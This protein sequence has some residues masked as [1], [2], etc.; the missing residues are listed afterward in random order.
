MGLYDMNGNAWEWTLD[1]CN[2]TNYSDGMV[3]ISTAANWNK[4]GSSGDG[5]TANNPFIDPVY[6]TG[7]ARA[8]RGGSWKHGA[9]AFPLGYRSGESVPA[10]LGNNISFRV[11]VAAA[12]AAQQAFTRKIENW[13]PQIRRK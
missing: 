3:Y 2:A 1:W 5:T 11:A 4:G 12:L 10:S 7:S 13:K 8:R 6:N 9:T